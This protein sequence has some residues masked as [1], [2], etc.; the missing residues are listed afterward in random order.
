MPT[1]WIKNSTGTFDHEAQPEGFAVFASRENKFFLAESSTP[2]TGEFVV[3]FPDSI[4]ANYA[5]ANW[6]DGKK[7]CGDPFN[8][9]VEY[10]GEVDK[11]G[12]RAI[13]YTAEQLVQRKELW[14]WIA[15]NLYVP[16]KER[17]TGDTAATTKHLEEIA[18]ISTDT[19]M[20]QYII[21]NLYY[22]IF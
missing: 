6:P 16:D 4:Y 9:A 3:E 7:P 5:M 12:R 10:V 1:Y 11:R 17:L 8:G 2:P 20:R 14:Q 19:D 13:L 18:L 21:D 15:V 22:D